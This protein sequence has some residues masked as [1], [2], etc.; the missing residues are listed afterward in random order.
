ML[1][2]RPPDP[3][4]AETQGSTARSGVPGGACDV[5][6]SSTRTWWSSSAVPP[7]WVRLRGPICSTK[8]DTLGPGIAEDRSETRELE[9][10]GVAILVDHG[11]SR[12]RLAVDCGSHRPQRVLLLL[13]IEVAGAAGYARL[14]RDRQ[15]VRPG[16]GPVHH[17]ENCAGPYPPQAPESL[18]SPREQ[19]AKSWS[20]SRP[21]TRSTGSESEGVLPS[22][23]GTAIASYR[24]KGKETPL[25]EDKGPLKLGIAV[26]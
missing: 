4:K 3:P 22:S 2:D 21:D 16:P 20:R 18:L 9:G 14:G 10:L 11:E 17:A 23:Q 25:L 7:W 5:E 15:Q 26:I 8:Q 13:C 1:P 19:S 6:A 12:I 24:Y